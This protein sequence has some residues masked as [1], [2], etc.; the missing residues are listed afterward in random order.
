MPF[1]SE[2][3]RRYLWKHHPKIAKDW[4]DEHGSKPVK[5]KKG[6]TPWYLGPYKR[7]QKIDKYLEQLKKKYPKLPPF[8]YF[9]KSPDM[10]KIVAGLSKK[11]PFSKVEK[12]KKKRRDVLLN[13]HGGSMDPYYGSYI[14]GRVDGKT[15]SNPSYRKYYKGLI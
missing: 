5:K 11:P 2:K 6:G 8:M 13:K 15:L 3:Q 4:T 7:A 12:V 9:V 14:K 1:R 10:A